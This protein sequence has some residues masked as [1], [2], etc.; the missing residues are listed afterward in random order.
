MPQDFILI[1]GAREHNLKNISLKIPRN[2]LVVITGLSGSGK[3]SLAFDTLYAEGQRRY[4]E[5]LSAYARQFLEMMDKPDVD[6]IEG[7]SPAIAIEQRNPS[8]NPRSTVGTVTE[9]YDYLRLLFARV[10]TPYCPQCKKLIQPQSASQIIS[11]IME[12]KAGTKIEILS[13][14]IRGR[15]G[16]YEELFQ[17]L[18]RSGYSR[19]RVDGKNVLLEEK[20]PLDRYKKHT[21]E[22]VVDRVEIQPEI[23]ERI[24]DSIET[25][26]KE[27][28]GVVEIIEQGKKEPLLFSEHYACT[29]C[30]ISL[31][32]IEP[33]MFS[34]NSPYGACPECDGIG[35]KVEVDPDLVVQEKDKSIL[36]GAIVAWNSPVT[37]RTHR[38]K[39][40]WREYYDDI[41][42]QV[43]DQYRISMEIPWKNLSENHKKILLYGGANAQIKSLWG[44]Q[45]KE[46]EG[47]I[48]NLE[49]RYKES[50]SEFVK[51][52]IMNLY[53]RKRTCPKCK[54][55]R[56]K[57][58]SLSVKIGQK[59]IQEISQ[60]SV[61]KAKIF[62]DSLKLGNIQE[63]IAKTI[64]K[65]ILARLE[66]LENV[67]LDYLT[68]SRESQTLAGGEAQRIHLATQIGSGLMGVLYVLDEP[69]IGLHQR[70]NKRLLDTLIRLKNLGNTLVV[71]EHDE[72]T[73][74][75]ADW[76]VD[77]GPGAGE[78][79]GEVIAQ[80]TLPEILKEKKSLTA[81]YLNGNLKIPL[82]K[83][84]E[85]NKNAIKIS[86][87]SQFNLKNI[88]LKIPLGIFVCVT[89]VS[90]S[91]KS[92]LVHEIIYKSLAQKLH[93]SKDIPGK[94][95]K[96]E[97]FEHLDKVIVVD[98]SPIGRTPRSNPATYTGA[99]APIREVFAQLQ[100]SR[101]KG[102]KPGR[103]SFNVKGGRCEN[104]QG[105][106]T[107]KISMQFL[108]DIYVKCEVCEGKRFNQETLQIKFKGKNIAEVLNLP[109]IEALTFFQAI[110]QIA[111]TLQTLQEVGLGYIK[112]GQSATTLSG[113]EAQ[114]VKLATEL[115]KRATGKTLYLLD[116]PT[117]GL[118]FA[119]VEKLLSVLHKL[120]GMGNSVLVIEHNLEVI[121]TADWIVDMG[122]EGGDLGGSVVAE[123]APKSICENPLSYTGQFLKK[124][125]E[126]K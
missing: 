31:P 102:Y 95:R 72:E 97:G 92:T 75:S 7:L 36:E 40:G 99:W 118:H 32:E 11:L 112:L 38:W 117:T 52:E 14:L 76:I 2:Q 70:D 47:V 39:Q 84:R 105:D 22:L 68:L 91:G 63:K 109:V 77:L 66:F 125:V 89:G 50:E 104:C 122:P 82:R 54:G 33:R 19:A 90:G 13:P 94:V 64:L 103:F 100:E 18:K 111:R 88:D 29:E 15:I 28:N 86:G 26:L 48:G 41:L 27:G 106:G 108:P 73:I 126:M 96:I 10:G 55:A 46:F 51:E 1:K 98:Q 6:L 45:E 30:G 114:R 16:T 17:K 3:S 69:S 58:E 42:K 49:R 116:E 8:H 87:A 56:L 79:G 44:S 37:T 80:G 34:F 4:V 62:F 85:Q 124:L 71:V 61:K 110:P 21:I 101:R 67:G 53:M 81:R 83:A 65:E 59:N 12:F 25:A 35:S 119:D 43:C 57:N 9:I 107:L 74:R 121:K 115:S 5:S 113:G 78:F 93:H 120:V 123:G 60:L 20:I 23:R 24:A